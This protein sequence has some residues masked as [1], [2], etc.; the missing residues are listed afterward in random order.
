MNF[1]L[2]NIN[3]FLGKPGIRKL[4][5]SAELKAWSNEQKRA[6]LFTEIDTFLKAYVFTETSDEHMD[7]FV[8]RVNELDINQRDGYPCRECGML[9]KYHSTRVEYVFLI[10]KFF[11]YPANS[12]IIAAR[13]LFKIRGC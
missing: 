5:S 10:I 2:Q 3:C 12:Q 7:E 1:I 6:W 8:T 9:F 4:P 13:H 11:S